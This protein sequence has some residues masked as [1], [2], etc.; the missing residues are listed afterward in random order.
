MSQLS[1]HDVVGNCRIAF[2]AAE[3]LGIPRVIEPREMNM[4]TVPDKLGVMTY[5]HQLR[6]HFTGKQLKIEQIG[7]L[8]LPKCEGHQPDDQLAQRH[9]L[10]RHHPSLCA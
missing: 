8:R 10:L 4:L 7:K 9:G 5:L 3:S 6:A 2:D 1:A